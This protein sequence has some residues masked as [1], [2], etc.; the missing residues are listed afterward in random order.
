M[1]AIKKY[2]LTLLLIPAIYLTTAR[3][4][5]P[6]APVLHQTAT[7]NQEAAG[8][9]EPG[10]FIGSAACQ[11]C[12]KEI[13]AAH[14]HTAHYLDSRPAAAAF[15]KG[16]FKG[17]KSRFVLNEHMEVR[18]EKKAG[19]FYQTAFF[20][21][22]PIE[23]EAFGIVI[24]SGRKGQTYLYWDAGRLFQLP[25]SY[26]VPLDSW[27]NSPGYPKN[28]IYF[29]KEARGQCIECHGTYAVTAELEGRGTVF[30]SASIIYGIDCERCHG[31][32]AEHVAW[33]AAH[34]GDLTARYIVNT[35]HLSRQQRL[36]ACAL[37]HSGFRKE[38]KPSFSF[39]VGDTLDNYSKA[40]YDT[41]ATAALDVHGNQ[42][43]LLTASKCFRLADG[44]D[45]SS[46]HNPHVNEHGRM[47]VYSQR[48]AGC[49]S[50]N[51]Q[52]SCSFSP[53][54][55]MGLTN[56]CI[57]CH[58]PAL[59]SNAI[60]LQLSGQDQLVHDL[61]RTHR[62]AIYPDAAKEYLEKIKHR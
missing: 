3:W 53:V 1:P 11:S 54:K 44:L 38:N 62:V 27:C 56:N 7:D 10:K 2:H 6:T 28:M 46:C 13:Y 35:R 61:V 51:G 15:I 58:M 42:Y 52:H 49:H 37:C 30:D 60:T 29:G 31:P 50:G 48:C 24:G 40:T 45:C 9:Q 26:F 34:P 57:D 33:Q 59:P 43:G 12:H 14:I 25:I 17:D 20:N 4:T 55:T 32:G 18:M 8:N 36:D 22:N 47:E 5:P 21:G 39:A 23:S 41:T 19:R 16:S